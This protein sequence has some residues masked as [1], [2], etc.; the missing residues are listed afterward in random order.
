MRT[1][2]YILVL[3]TALAGQSYA[4]NNLLELLG[5][6]ALKATAAKGTKL[7]EA[8]DSVDFQFAVSVNPLSTKRAAR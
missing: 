7:M 1:K 3:F 5:N 8:V 6:Q 4:Q 2:L